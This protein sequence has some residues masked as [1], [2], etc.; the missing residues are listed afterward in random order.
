MD[1]G[2]VVLLILG[3][4]LGYYLVNHYLVTRQVA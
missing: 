3:F 2:D 4:L 1:F